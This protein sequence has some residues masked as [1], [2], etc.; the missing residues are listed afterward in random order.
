[1]DVPPLIIAG[2]HRSGTSATAR[3]LALAGLD[4]GGR[5]LG[6]HPDNPLGYYEDLA[7]CDLN[8]ALVAAG[9]DHG[10]SDRGPDW[11]HAH[12]VEP[13]RLL[14]LR[15]RA[16]ALLAARRARG[17]AWGFKDPRATILLD[18]Y[19]ALAP[20][21]RYLFVYRAPWEVLDSLVRTHARPLQGRPDLAIQAWT[22]YNA[23]ALAFRERHPD[24]TVLAHIDVVAD[25][26]GELVEL[27]RER[28]HPV[29]AQALDAGRASGAF[30]GELLKR[31]PPHSALAELV[32][33]HHR[34]AVDLYARMDAAADLAPRSPAVPTPPEVDV[35]RRPG[36]LAVGVVLAGAPADGAEHARRIARPR[37]GPAPAR[38]ADA[39]MLAMREER[40]AVLFAGQLRPTALDNAVR[41][42]DADDALAAVLLAPRDVPPRDAEPHD[43][44]S[45]VD[46]GAGIVVRRA[47]WIAV[48]GFEALRA[49]A[50]LEGWWFAVACAA[51]HLRVARVDGALR[52]DGAEV[53]GDAARRLVLSAHPALAARWGVEADASSTRAG[54]AAV[55]A[56]ERASVAEQRARD[57]ESERDALAEQLAALHATRAWR[58]AATWWRLKNLATGPSR[59]RR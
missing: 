14:P 2:M 51:R 24:R 7:F 37:E 1:V 15:P 21:A 33:V 4:V 46:A 23:H 49:P 45:R 41:A 9:V 52:L 47:A 31:T 5:L 40:V 19:D 25:R 36:R 20:D 54:A 53:D 26:P 38:R 35:E 3:L 58:L 56:E 50:G 39:G 59:A 16:S 10:V 32:G 8:L 11:A 12:Y 17:R 34:E 28:S 57:A 13:A 27:V 18:F 22:E 48:R 30:V 6:P 42:L 55:A 29:T 44:L 43:P